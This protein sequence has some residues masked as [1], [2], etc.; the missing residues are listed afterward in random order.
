MTDLVDIQDLKTH[1]GGQS[2][3]I[4]RAAG[5]AIRAVDGVTLKIAGGDTMGLVGESGCG[6]S[7]L[8]RSIVRLHRPTAGR[9]LYDGQ[10]MATVS[11]SQLRRMR[12]RVQM[13]FQDP[14]S[15]LDPRMRIGDTLAEPLRVH[16]LARGAAKGRRVTE[17]LELVGMRAE[18][19]DRFPHEFS[20]GQR[21]RIGIARALSVDPAFLI[22]DEPV[23]ALDASVQA[24]ILNLLEDLRNQLNLTC[25]FIAHD[26]SVVRHICSRVAVM[27]LGK[28]VEVA[29]K[30]DLFA[31]PLHPY[32]Q[33][34]LSAVPVPEPSVERKRQRIILSG[35]VPSAANP[36]AG[37]RFHTRCPFA[38][39]RCRVDEPALEEKRPGHVVACHLVDKVSIE[40]VR[41]S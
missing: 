15:S 17:L 6:K 25:L 39:D 13:V 19:A 20:G 2:H 18:A 40:P 38:I 16:R 22:C 5:S 29:S 37:C 10:D 33:A 9:I 21:Q 32:T 41:T 4:G 1:F 11:G 7:T 26:L 35:D 23:S 3:S 36:P 12:R 24:Q 28:I 27:Y 14:F 8:G 31:T 34:L 30:D